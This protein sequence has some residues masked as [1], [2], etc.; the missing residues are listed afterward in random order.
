ML[1]DMEVRVELLTGS[2]K[3]AKRKAILEALQAGEVDILVGTHALIEP[4]VVFARLGLAVID[5]QHRFG[6]AQRAKLWE[7]G[8]GGASHFGDDGHAD[9]ENVGHDRVRRP[10]RQHLG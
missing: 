1:G 2:V 8:E 3:G 4:T 10:R 9:S 6:V 5:E 7:E